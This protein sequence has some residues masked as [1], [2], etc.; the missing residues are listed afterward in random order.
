MEQYKLVD[1]INNVQ[2]LHRPGDYFALT[3]SGTLESADS[4]AADA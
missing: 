3:F 2:L 1:I 4:G